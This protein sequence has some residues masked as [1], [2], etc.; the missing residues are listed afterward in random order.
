MQ[1]YLAE[2]AAHIFKWQLSWYTDNEGDPPSI[3][4][5]I[6]LTERAATLSSDDILAQIP[7]YNNA[8]YF[9]MHSS[10]VAARERADRYYE[11]LVGVLEKCGQ[12]EGSWPPNVID[13]IIW[14]QWIR[15]NRVAAVDWNK[16]ISR[17]EAVLGRSDMP[18][19]DKKEI[20]AHIAA[21]RGSVA[22]EKD[23]LSIDTLGVG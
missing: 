10:D 20:E 21:I 7:I 3:E 8:C 11:A 23:L 1:G 19:T 18:A 6:E 15:R 14:S 9:F 12:D 4:K 16:C 22:E 2:R 5:A 17:L 13:A